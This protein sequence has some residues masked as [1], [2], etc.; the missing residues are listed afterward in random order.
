MSAYNW[1]AT[2]AP[3]PRCRRAEKILAQTHVASD[4]DGDDTGRFHDRTY[5]LGD[6]MHWW[7]PSDPRYPEW[8]ANR[9]DSTRNAVDIDDE[10]CHATC[11]ICSTPLFVLLRFNGPRP[12]ELLALGPEDEWP[13]GC[14]K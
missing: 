12:I 7:P 8:R 10:A 14:L 13:V 3:C 6:A 1:I 11:T 2:T 9:C 5:E 4:Y